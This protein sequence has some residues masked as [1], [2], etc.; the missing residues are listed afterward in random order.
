MVV[1]EEAWPLASISSEIAFKVQKDAFDY[2]DES[3]VLENEPFARLA[4]DNQMHAYQHEGF[5]QPM[6]TYREFKLL[7]DLWDS[8]EA[9]WKVW[10]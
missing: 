10:K 3:S 2:L 1:V 9:P 8:N 7:N 6:D 5:W 4:K